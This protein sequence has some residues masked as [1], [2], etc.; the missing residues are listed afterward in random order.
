MSGVQTCALPIWYTVRAG[1]VLTDTGLQK[2]MGGGYDV[3][4]ANIVSDVIIALAPAVGRLMKADGWFLTSGIIDSRE[5]E[6][7]AA[8]ETAGFAVE[9]AAASE[10]WCS[11]LCR[12]G[13]ESGH[14]ISL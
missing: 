8:L 4:A 6:V 2:E 1:D 3:V 11:F 9:E 12:K 7:R 13:K 5:E 10:G 14:A